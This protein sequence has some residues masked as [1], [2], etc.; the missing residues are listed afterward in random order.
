MDRFLFRSLPNFHF[1]QEYLVFNTVKRMNVDG[2]EDGETKGLRDRVR[3]FREVS[4]ND[5]LSR[6]GIQLREDILVL[7]IGRQP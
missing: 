2:E 6:L 5:P 3:T 4:W 7:Q 1:I